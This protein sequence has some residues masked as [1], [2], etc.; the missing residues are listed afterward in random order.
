MCLCLALDYGSR[1]EIVEAVQTIAAKAKSGELDPEAIDEDT[2]ASHL[3]TGGCV[4][5]DLV[6]RTAGEMRISNFLLWQIS[7]AELW[8][9]DKFWPDFRENDLH[10][11]VRSFGSRERRFGSL[12]DHSLPDAESFPQT[13]QSN[14]TISGSRASSSRKRFTAAFDFEHTAFKPD[15]FQRGST[16]QQVNRGTDNEHRRAADH[17]DTSNL[18]FE[19]CEQHVADAQ[20]RQHSGTHPQQDPN[21]ER[22]AC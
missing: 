10:D 12:Q 4:D 21:P 14:V 22:C 15:H 9:T 2:V 8:V 13:N 17:L 19:E 16:D 7:Y 1:T 6:I 18:L 11:A 3:Y 5:P 20:H